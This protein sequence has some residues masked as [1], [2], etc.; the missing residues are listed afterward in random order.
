MTTVRSSSTSAAP[1]RQRSRDC[2]RSTAPSSSSRWPHSPVPRRRRQPRRATLQAERPRR[3]DP[4]RATAGVDRRHAPRRLEVAAQGRARATSDGR[5]ASS[6]SRWNDSSGFGH[7]RSLMIAT[8]TGA[9]Y[10]LLPQLANIDDSIEALRS[11]NWG[12]LAGCVRRCPGVTYVA[13]GVGLTG[14]IPRTDPA[15]ADHPRPTGLV[16]RQPGDAGQRWR[17]GAQRALP[18]EGRGAIGRS[19]HRHWA[20]RPCRRDRPPRAAVRVL[21]LGRPERQRLL[22]AEQQPAARRHRRRP[23]VARRRDGDAAWAPT[24]AARTSCRPSSSRSRASSR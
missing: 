6:R 5:P 2:R 9:F 8:L 24:A 16:V 4:V 18:A 10:F 11:A 14:G 12:W 22:D 20:Q 17:H 21:R 13:A 7:A 15:G 23:G 1:W 19:G 3:G